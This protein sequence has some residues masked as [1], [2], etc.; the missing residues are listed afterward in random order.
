MN[1]NSLSPGTTAGPAGPRWTLAAAAG[2]LST[3]PTGVLFTSGDGFSALFTPVAGSATAYTSPAGVKADLVKTGSAGWTL[4][5][6]TTATVLTLDTDGN[7]TAVTDRNANPTTLAWASGKLSNVVSTRGVAGARTAVLGYDPGSGLLAGISQASGTGSRSVSFAHDGAGNLTGF[8][9][10]TGNTTTF[11]YTAGQVSTITSPA[12]GITNLGYDSTG[13]VTAITGTDTS[14]G[15]PGNSVTRFAY[16]TGSQTLVAGPDT[17]QSLSVSAVPHTTY[18]LDAGDHV[19]AATDAAGRAQSTTYT[20]D[21]DT[22]TATQ[23]T[24]TSAGTTTNT[25][26]A[27]TGQS[28]TASQAPGGSTGQAAYANTAASTKYLA[29]SSTDDAGNTSLYTFDGAGNPLTAA[30]ATAATAA[31]TYNPDGTVATALAPGNGTNKTVYGYDIN[32]QLTTLTPVTGSS[33]GA[34]SFT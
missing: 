3:A 4:T 9:D 30:D 25:Y 13:R 1:F 24:G 10:L 23:G 19:T 18:T 6:R 21:F 14:T 5:S 20:A 26:G 32:H 11:A 12:G 7:T 16:P 8:T 22:L 15:S 34:R 17:G 2:S 28:I 31:L 27:N 29:S 33:L